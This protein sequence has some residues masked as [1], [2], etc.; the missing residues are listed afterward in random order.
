MAS[1][2]T[3][4]ILAAGDLLMAK[5]KKDVIVAPRKE[6]H[7]PHSITACGGIEFV[8]YEWRQVPAGTEGEAERNPYLELE[9]RKSGSDSGKAV[10]QKK[11]PVQE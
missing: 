9:I 2:K 3:K 5:V 11:E 1:P 7:S 8:D 4:T 10:K 6:P